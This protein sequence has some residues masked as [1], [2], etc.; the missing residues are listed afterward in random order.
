MTLISVFLFS[1]LIYSPFL[2][3]EDKENK[4]WL[5]PFCMH[6]SIHTKKDVEAYIKKMHLPIECKWAEKKCSDKFQTKLGK[7]WL[8]VDLHK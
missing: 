4:K 5:Y 2:L 7:K 3:L 8:I 1:L 6:S